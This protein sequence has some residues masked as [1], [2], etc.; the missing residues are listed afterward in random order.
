MTDTQNT[1]ALNPSYWPSMNTR[2]IAGMIAGFIAVFLA[3]K[4]LNSN[5]G[6]SV[7]LIDHLSRLILFASLT[8]WV[9]LCVGIQR[10]GSA[11][12]IALAFATF[13]D[14]IFVPLSGQPMGT[15]LSTNLGIVLAY[16]GLQL[17]WYQLRDKPEVS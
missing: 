16:S 2:R 3:I 12:V 14:L 1:L 9:A 4:V 17:Y 10:R 13:A 6:L 8:V 11:A 15:V 7:D 5:L